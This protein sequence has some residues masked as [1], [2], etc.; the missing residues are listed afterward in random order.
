MSVLRIGIGHISTSYHIRYGDVSVGGRKPG[1]GDDGDVSVGHRIIL[2]IVKIIPVK[3]L[4]C[5]FSSFFF[6][7]RVTVE[8]SPRGAMGYR[9]TI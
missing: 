6:G 8:V 4:D 7:N 2:A 3:I 9:G 5:R 1:E